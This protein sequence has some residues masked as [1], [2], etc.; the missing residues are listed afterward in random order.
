MATVNIQPL[1]DW[2]RKITP[3]LRPMPPPIFTDGE[4]TRA[5]RELALELWRALDR[6]SQAWYGDLEAA[7]A[8]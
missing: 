7:W 3:W 4:P 8:P 6:E 5:D 2:A 1:S